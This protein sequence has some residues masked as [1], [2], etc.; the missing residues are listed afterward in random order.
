MSAAAVPGQRRPM[1]RPEVASTLGGRSRNELRGERHR[2]L[3]QEVGRQAASA[4]S[5]GEGS[6]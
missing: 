3:F 1:G 5:L 4:A 6:R 2:P